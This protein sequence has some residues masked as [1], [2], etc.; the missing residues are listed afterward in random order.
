MRR[1]RWF[2]L[3]L[4]FTLVQSGCTTFPSPEPV[5]G[6]DEMRELV[7]YSQYQTAM[8][9]GSDFAR[10]PLIWMQQLSGVRGSH[11]MVENYE[12]QH[13]HFDDPWRNFYNEVL[14]SFYMAEIFA[15]DLEAQ[16]FRGIIQIHRAFLLAAFTDA[17][18][19]VPF[20][21]SSKYYG[22]G[23]NPVYDSQE[24]LYET[25]LLKI[26]QGLNYLE[27][28][29]SDPLVPR[30]SEDVFYGGSIEQWKKVAR[31]LRLKLSLRLGNQSG[32]YSMAL[33]LLQQGGMFESAGDDMFFPFAI[34]PE[35]ENPWHR[36]DF[37]VGNTRMGKKFV[38]MLH[39]TDDPR[40]SRFVRLNT[41]NQ[42]IGA[43]PGSA[44]FDASRIANAVGSVGARSAR[45]NLLTYCEQKF[46]EAEVYYRNGWQSQADE[47][48]N[49]AVIASLAMYD[50]RN[51][52]WE[53]VHANRTDV[54]LEDIIEAKYIALFL[55]PEVWSDWRRTGYP[56]I[57]DFPPANVNEDRVPRRFL[58]PSVEEQT[59]PFNY[60]KEVGVNTRIWWDVE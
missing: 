53:E 10:Y 34:F 48:Y 21:E 8:F 1:L 27:N 41:Q 6:E 52:A 23:N 29:G 46:I 38:D 31:L 58:Y 54:D 35:Q 60:P 33:L 42:R 30:P 50:A 11:L 47:A 4:A 15:F 32:D 25:L 51:A 36:F 59:N 2:I 7:L 49:Q 9:M 45:L 16:V 28:P 40:L 20:Y 22:G 17:W 5:T 43:S 19:D 57:G 24:E 3:I 39:A 55:N 56:E 12:P 14:Q 13:Q 18:G 37:A 44:N 26:E